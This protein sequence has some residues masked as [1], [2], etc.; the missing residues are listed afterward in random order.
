MDFHPGGDLLSAM[1]RN[2]GGM[3]ELDTR[4]VATLFICACPP[5]Y[6]SLEKKSCLRICV[7][8]WVSELQHCTQCPYL[9]PRR[10]YLTEIASGLHD[11]HKLGF[12]HRDIKPE[13]VLITRSGHI[14]LVDFGSAARLDPDGK[15]VSEPSH[16]RVLAKAAYAG[17]CQTPNC[18]GR[19]P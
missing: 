4:S 16:T 9:S 12:V 2:E 13:N 8:F 17:R 19:C 3:S 15:V 1:E 11:L 18:L 7:C 6:F 5:E 14:K 10:F